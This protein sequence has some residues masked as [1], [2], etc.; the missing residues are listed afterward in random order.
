ME[1]WTQNGHPRSWAAVGVASSQCGPVHLDSSVPMLQAAWR[2]TQSPALVGTK[3]R[4]RGRPGENG[5]V[6]EAE[7]RELTQRARGGWKVP[8]RKGLPYVSSKGPRME[9][10]RG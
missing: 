10:S 7:G 4:V 2:N 8:S 9:G 1:E 3:G 5:S 6:R